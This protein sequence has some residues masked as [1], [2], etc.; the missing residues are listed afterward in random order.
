[1]DDL[2]RHL[3]DALAREEAP[4]EFEAR[5]MSA[6]NQAG[7][8]NRGRARPHF[9]ERPRWQWIFATATAAAVVVIGVGTEWE[10]HAAMERVKMAHFE[11]EQ[12]EA[13]QAAKAQLQLALRITST[14]LEEIQQRIGEGSH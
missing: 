12:R 9:G 3:K 1:M 2:E 14:K 13:G 5:V 7:A 8:S 4:A 6:V 11:M 10:H